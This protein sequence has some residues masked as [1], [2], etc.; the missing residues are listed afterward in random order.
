MLFVCFS[1]MDGLVFKIWWMCEG[2]WFEGIYVWVGV[3]VWD[4]FV[5]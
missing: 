2:E 4:G 5:E 3:V 1:G